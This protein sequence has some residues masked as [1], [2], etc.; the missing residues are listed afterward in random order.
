M[1]T[2]E[3]DK[4]IA[5]FANSLQGKSKVDE[6][7]WDITYNVITRTNLVDCVVYLL[8]KEKNVL[9]QKAAF[10]NKNTGENYILNPIEIP[11]GKGIVGSVALSGKAEIVKDTSRDPRYITDDSK[12]I[13]ELEVPIIADKKVIGVI[14]S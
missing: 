9:V 8:D 13:S 14:D 7:L 3:S 2:N 10:G 6:L 11:L 5:Y 12:R 4:A 1:L